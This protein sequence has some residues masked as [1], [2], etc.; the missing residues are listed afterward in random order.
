M[1]NSNKIRKITVLEVISFMNKET[2]ELTG[3]LLPLNLIVGVDHTIYIESEPRPLKRR[4]CQIEETKKG[5]NVYLE[6]GTES[7]LWKYIPKSNK[8]IIEFVID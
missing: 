3:A 2:G 1:I 5:Y 4:I 6:N 7:Q 8:V